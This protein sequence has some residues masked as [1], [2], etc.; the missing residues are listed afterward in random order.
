M[1]HVKARRDAGRRGFTLVELLVVIGIIAI[2]ISILLPVLNKAREQAKSVMCMSNEKQIMN[3]FVMYVAAHRGATPI[4]PPVAKYY[5]TKGTPFDRSL[6]YYMVPTPGRAGSGVIRYDEG[7]LWPYLANS[8]HYTD[9][10]GSAKPI[11]PPPEVLYRIFNCPTDTDF[12]SVENGG[13]IDKAVSVLRNFSYSWNAS[14]WCDPPKPLG[15]GSPQLWSGTSHDIHAVS[16]ISQIIEPAHKIVLEEEMRPNDGWSFV[17]WLPSGNSDDLP[18][19]RHSGRGNWGF[20]DGHVESLSCSDIGYTQPHSNLANDV[21]TKVAGAD[22]TWANYF[23]LQS[24][25]K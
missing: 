1:A 18:S 8:L 16:R 24:N 11:G 2:L 3:A 20:A 4:F 12:R 7:A 15:T 9:T 14:F 5:T 13:T 10:S 25:A 6:A 23:H 17:G 21:P 22:Q 19:W